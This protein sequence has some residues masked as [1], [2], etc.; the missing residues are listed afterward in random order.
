M[1]GR[2]DADGQ[3]GERIRI[4]GA[5]ETL[6][7]LHQIIFHVRG[8]LFSLIFI[9]SILKKPGPAHINTLHEKQIY[10]YLK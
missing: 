10:V 7:P 4:I 9:G 5:V 3:P 1:R 8:R 6:E 2:R